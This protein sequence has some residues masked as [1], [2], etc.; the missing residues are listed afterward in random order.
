LIFK[1]LI[2]ISWLDCHQNFEFKFLSTLCEVVKMYLHYYI[3][4]SGTLY[5]SPRESGTW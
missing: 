3:R 5:F 2:M 4:F 1:L